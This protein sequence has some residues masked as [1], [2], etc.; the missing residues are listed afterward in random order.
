M[1]E[2]EG[3][4]KEYPQAGESVHALIGVDLKVAA[5]EAVAILGPSG[6]GKST[7]LHILG[8][9]DSPTSGRYVLN[10]ADVSRLVG[11]DLARVR[12]RD[13]GFVFQRFHLVS[14]LDATDNVALPLRFGGVARRERRRRAAELLERVGLSDRAGHRPAELSGGQQQRVAIARALAC[15][16]RLLLADEPTGALDQAVGAEILDLLADLNAGG[17]TLVVVTHDEAL[18]ARLPRQVRM[19]DGTIES[20]ERSCERVSGAAQGAD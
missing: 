19:L 2:L 10:G 17:T 12:N 20:D 13:V 3:I 14:R 4:G 7:L 18:A 9:L 11:N 1:I 5:G 16:P 6:S 15:G 8:L